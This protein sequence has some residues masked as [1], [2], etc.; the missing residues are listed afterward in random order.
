MQIII[1]HGSPGNGKTTM[2]NKLHEYFKSPWFE[3]GWIPE[4]NNLN[5]HTE[6]SFKDEEEMTFETLTIVIRNYMKHGFENLILSDLNDVRLLEIPAVFHD[7]DYIIFTLFSEEDDV[8]KNRILTRDNGN[9]YRNY[10]ESIKL[11]RIIKKR[12]RLPNEFRLRSDN[13]T[14]DE[15]LKQIVE[16]ISDHKC[17]NVFVPEEYQRSDYFSYT[18]EAH[19]DE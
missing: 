17:N 7:F 10:D 8:I 15:L 4:F 11:N 18:E 14:P 1:M 19:F 3:F 2:A 5:P 13:Q 12:K 9:E 16:I 6:M